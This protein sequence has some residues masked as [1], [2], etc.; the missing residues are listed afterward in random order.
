MSILCL[1]MIV[2]NE[3]KIIERLL[4]TVLPII[5]SFCICDTGSTDNTV[6]VI[7]KFMKKAGKVG[8]VY[9][10][11]FKNFGYNRDHAL[12]RAEKWGKY[13]L[14]LDADMKLIVEPGFKKET[15]TAD[16]Y[17]IIQ[18]N[19]SMQ[20]YNTR[21][22]K[23][24][25]GVRCVC[26]THEYYDFPKNTHTEKLNT[27]WINDIGDGGCKTNKFER[28]IRLLLEG[29]RGE[30]LNGRYYFYLANSYRDLGKSKE[31]IINY[32]K[33]VEIGGWI[34]EIF[35]SCKEIGNQYM[36]LGDEP[37]AVFWW[38][39]AY[40]RHPT[41]AE[42]L[43]QLTKYYREKGKQQIGQAICNLARS[44]PFPKDDV[45]FIETPVY[46]FLLFYEHTILTYYTNKDIDHIKYLDLIGRKHDF[47][48]V[49]KNYQYYV[50]NLK[51]IG[52]V[53]TETASDTCITTDKL[54]IV[55]DVPK[56]VGVMAP[57]LMTSHNGENWY[58]CNLDFSE[59][60]YH[61]IVVVDSESR[62]LKRHSILF[63]IEG[64]P[65]E[66]CKNIEVTETE[67]IISSDSV[68]L[69]VPHDKFKSFLV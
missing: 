6:E 66:I 41:R 69:S 52:N 5:D 58:V 13:A 63:R 38:L 35:M 30:P 24:G 22:V 39:E 46:E 7:E 67:F 34:E 28:D 10:E 49:V 37:N 64:H 3:S 56:Y 9:S 11:P 25:I 21:I 68:V 43:Y 32:K 54:D 27:L 2:K 40:N 4:E 53:L 51:N 61:M 57:K 33:R 62:V 16:G 50:K 45:L 55:G 18:K 48:N 44:I 12:K 60:I 8:E 1:N 42:S 65:K 26:P 14:L 59:N 20:Y 36:K 15:L 17:S 23:T 29:I 47:N 19:P 31:A